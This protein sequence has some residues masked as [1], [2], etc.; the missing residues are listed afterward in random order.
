VNDLSD[1][2]SN[3]ILGLGF[4]FSAI[5]IALLFGVTTSVFAFLTYPI[6]VI[7]RI[8]GWIKLRQYKT[9]YLIIGVMIIILSPIYY[10]GFLMMET[11]VNLLGIAFGPLLGMLIS[12][13]IIYSI[14][15]AIGY[16]SLGKES[17]RLF[18]GALISLVGILIV[19]IHIP[20][21]LV[22]K[23]I[24]ILLKL[25]PALPFLLISSIIAAIS[26]FKISKS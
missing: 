20:T 25:Y 21:I 5:T 11:W 1:K 12:V 8:I 6:S 23:S 17:T 14:F 13:W 22:S 15:E 4:I 26:S 3:P 19:V 9:L 16:F 10:L 18:Y 7:L 2:G 24:N